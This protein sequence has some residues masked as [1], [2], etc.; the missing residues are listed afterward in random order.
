MLRSVNDAPDAG[1]AS[2]TKWRIDLV[3]P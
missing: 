1:G 2:L 3:N